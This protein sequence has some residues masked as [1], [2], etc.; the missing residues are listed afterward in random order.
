MTK[1]PNTGQSP[2]KCWHKDKRMPRVPDGAFLERASEKEA[3]RFRSAR[4]KL[5][6]PKH[7]WRP[8]AIVLLQNGQEGTLKTRS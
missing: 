2:V 4:T 5:G 8:I 7:K 6:Q 3:N 1:N